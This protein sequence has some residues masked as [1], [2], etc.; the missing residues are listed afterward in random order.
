MMGVL[1]L[2]PIVVALVMAP[3]V[4]LRT[5]QIAELKRL[6]HEV[7]LMLAPKGK[8]PAPPPDLAA[9]AA[10]EATV[11]VNAIRF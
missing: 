10:L 5:A 4:A 3:L 2:G 6:D 8:K 9:D 7:R 1:V 11:E